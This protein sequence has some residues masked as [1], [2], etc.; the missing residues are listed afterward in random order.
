MKSLSLLIVV[1]F[2]FTST[3]AQ[4]QSAGKAMY[5]MKGISLENHIDFD[6]I[7][8]TNLYGV[9]PAENLQGEITI[10]NGKILHSSIENDEIKTQILAK[11]KSPFAA[12]TKVDQ[13]ISTEV[14]VNI[15]SL[16]EFEKV[17]ETT[18]E[19]LNLDLNTAFAFKVEA[20]ISDLKFHIIQKDL[21][22][23]SHSH[24]THKDSKHIFERQHQ[25]SVLLG[26]YSQNHQ[27]VFTHKGDFIHVHYAD[28]NLEETGHL[29]DI[30]H[31]GKIK[32]YF[33][34]L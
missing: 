8:K 17:I 10:F 19:N 6:S 11:T 22:Q 3:F 13:W 27:G 30:E 34:K 4:V 24:Q 15:T 14:D 20:E 5:V 12:Y 7:P 26:F 9:A 33:Q 23:K 28:E 1:L 16:S 18:A 25:N 32:I 29:D 2:C 21:T 31:A